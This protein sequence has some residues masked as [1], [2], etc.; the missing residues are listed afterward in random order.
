[1]LPSHITMAATCAALL[2]FS[3][4]SAQIEAEP[5]FSFLTGSCAHIEP[6]LQDSANGVM[7]R[8]DTSI[9][10]T[11]ANTGGEFMIW[12]GDNWYLGNTEAATG[13]GLNAKAR[14]AQSSPVL[15]RLL[16]GKTNYAIWDDHDYGPDNSGADFPLKT[17]SRNIFMRTWKSNPSYGENDEGIYT[18]FERSDALFILLDDRWWRSPDNM[19]AKK[20]G[21]PNPEKRMLGAYQMDWLQKVLAM[22][23]DARFKIIVN[24]SQVLNPIAKGDALVHYPVEYNELMSFLDTSGINGVVFL[25]GDRHHGEIIKL[26]RPGKYPLYDITSSPLTSDVDPVRGREKKNKYRVPNTLVQVQ[27]FTRFQFKGEGRNRKLLITYRDNRGRILATHDILATELGW[28][29]K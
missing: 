22:H 1:M 28:Q 26:D 2:C 16:T 15:Q 11:M 24:G 3:V 9:F 5:Q 6:S 13:E 25:T 27:H 19:R 4:S 14:R 8:G 20:K 18:Y 10:Y 29:L 7:Y 21:K 23:K 17:E 12:L